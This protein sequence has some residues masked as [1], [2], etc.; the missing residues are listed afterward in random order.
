MAARM[1]TT[2]FANLVKPG[3]RRVSIQQLQ[4]TP[5]EFRQIFNVVAGPNPGGEA[6]RN[7]FDDLLIS[8]MGTFIAKGEGTSIQ[9]DRVAEVGTVR[10]T[11]YAYA[12]GAR[13][14]HEMW[15]DE[16]YGVMSKIYRLIARSGLHQMEVQAFRVL[17]FGFAGTGNAGTGFTQAGFD[18]NTGAT[19]QLFNSAHTLKRGGTIAN[20]AAVDLDLSVTSVENASD[21]LELNVDEAGMPD[22][23]HLEHLVIPPQLKW[24]AREITES[25]L[26]P[27]TGDNEVNPLGGEGISYMMVHYFID[28]DMWIATGPKDQH[29]LNV[30]VREEPMFDA[31]DDFDSKDVKVSGMFRIAE[32]HGDFRGTFGSQGA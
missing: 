4:Q 24:I 20:R 7:F 3:L 28:P 17:N 15:E 5:K 26:K 19:G 23:R 14:T 8:P 11:P 6:G 13:I 25:E 27:Y 22:P 2:Q 10:Y 1:M 12:L 32:G 16:L 21:L 18:I 29:D 9:Y 31:G 30:W